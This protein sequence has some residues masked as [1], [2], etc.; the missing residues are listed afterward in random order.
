MK[1]I[2]LIGKLNDTIKYI[3]EYLSEYFQ[4]QLSSE[5]AK[6]VEGML[7]IMK[8]DLVI[9]SLIGLYSDVDDKIFFLL[10]DVYPEVP[11]LTIGTES[12]CSAYIK[13]YKEKQFVN[14]IRPIS[15]SDILQHCF[16][17]LNME[18]NEEE[19]QIEEKEEKKHLIVVDDNPVVLRSMKKI[20]DPYYSVSV[21]TSGAQAM[22]AIGRKRPDLIILDYEMPVCNG[23]QTFEMIRTDKELQDIPVIFL[24]G[25]ADKSHIEAVLRLKPAGYFLKPVPEKK[26]LEAIHNTLS[27]KQ[28]D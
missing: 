7:K 11:V 13:Y 12:E 16:K 18:E 23:K 21:A 1:K 6:T 8:P 5:N 22:T 19:V 27:G 26:L 4:V 15:N 25:V 14:L 20:L 24:T 3:N 10:S 17:R 28:K 9:I 2:L